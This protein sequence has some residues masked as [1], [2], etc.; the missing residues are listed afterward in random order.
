MTHDSQRGRR[1]GLMA[2]ALVVALTVFA[3]P[4]AA[5]GPIFNPQGCPT[6]VEKAAPPPPAVPKSAG[7]LQGNT[8]LSD[9]GDARILAGGVAVLVLIVAGMLVSMR[10]RDVHGTQAVALSGAGDGRR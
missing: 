3:A 1:S 6:G 8:C 4:A 5:K 7:T 10:R 2:L 9:S